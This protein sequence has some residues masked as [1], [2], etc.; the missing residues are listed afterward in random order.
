LQRVI[1][2][3]GRSSYVVRWPSPVNQWNRSRGTMTMAFPVPPLAF[4]QLEQWHIH[5]PSTSPSIA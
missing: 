1:E 2:Y 3:V 5:T 4:R